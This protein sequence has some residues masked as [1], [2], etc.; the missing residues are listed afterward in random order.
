MKKIEVKLTKDGFSIIKSIVRRS[1]HLSE[2]SIDFDWDWDVKTNR[3]RHVMF[4]H[5]NELELSKFLFEVQLKNLRSFFVE[6]DIKNEILAEKMIKKIL[7]TINK[8]LV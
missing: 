5:A 4:I 6:P 8:D 1:K 2:T 3:F 7:K